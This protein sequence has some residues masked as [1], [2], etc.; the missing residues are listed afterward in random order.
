MKSKYLIFVG[1]GIELVGI[2][3]ACLYIGQRV[4]QQYGLKGLGLAGFSLFGLA[5]WLIHIVRLTKSLENAKENPRGPE[6]P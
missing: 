2:M 6:S 4:D 5:G 3:I 1:M